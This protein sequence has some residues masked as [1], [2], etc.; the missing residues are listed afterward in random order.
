M[1]P[2]GERIPPFPE[3]PHPPKQ[4][5]RNPRVSAGRPCGPTGGGVPTDPPRRTPT[6]QPNTH[7]S[8]TGRH[9]AATRRDPRT[10]PDE[11]DRA[12]GVTQRTERVQGTGVRESEDPNTAEARL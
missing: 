1:A 11:A 12:L 4:G 9:A 5:K 2:K 8:S 3:A 10:T 6:P 7:P